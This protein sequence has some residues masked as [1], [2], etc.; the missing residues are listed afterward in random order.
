M[1]T[2]GGAQRQPR[3]PGQGPGT[4][5]GGGGAGRDRIGPTANGKVCRSEEGDGVSWLFPW[6]SPRNGWA[7]SPASQ[8]PGVEQRTGSEAPGASGTPSPTQICARVSVAAGQGVGRASSVFVRSWKLYFHV[9]VPNSYLQAFKVKRNSTQAACSGCGPQTA[10]LA[11]TRHPGP[12]RGV[13]RS[14]RYGRREGE[15]SCFVTSPPSK[16]LLPAPS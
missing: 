6:G 12:L 9:M 15:A 14:S 11:S 8:A 2:G 7:L 4:G 5:A 3:S 10:V 16:F 13:C 1:G